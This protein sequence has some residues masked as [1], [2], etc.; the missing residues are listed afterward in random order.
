MGFSQWA[1]GE[2]TIWGILWRWKHSEEDKWGIELFTTRNGWLHSTRAQVLSFGHQ[3]QIFVFEI[4]VAEF[5]AR[6]HTD[7]PKLPIDQET[8]YEDIIKGIPVLKGVGDGR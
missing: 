5:F 1:I 3:Q 8:I 7:Y 2:G 4:P 6:A